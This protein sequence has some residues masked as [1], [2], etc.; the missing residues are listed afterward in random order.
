MNTR[1]QKTELQLLNEI[2]QFIKKAIGTEYNS[3]YKENEKLLLE[4]ARRT[5]EYLT[6]RLNHHTNK[7]SSNL[8]ATIGKQWQRAKQE[9]RWGRQTARRT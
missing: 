3:L 6:V 7:K 8:D 2:K 5:P 1:R 9:L 4:I